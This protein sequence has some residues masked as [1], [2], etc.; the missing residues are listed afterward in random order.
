MWDV[1]LVEKGK[2]IAEC[3]FRIANLKSKNPEFRIQESG[4]RRSS[5]LKGESVEGVKAVE[6]V[7]ALIRELEN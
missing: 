6:V 7:K 3:G 2:M 5:K 4:E 1:R